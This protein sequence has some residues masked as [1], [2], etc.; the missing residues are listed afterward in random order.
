MGKKILA[1]DDDAHIRRI[2]QVSLERAGY[3]VATATNGVE[4]L[5]LLD[6]VE[7]DLVILDINMPY[8]DG[9]EVLKSMKDSPETASIP[10][11]MLTA[12]TADED[13]IKGWESGADSYLTKPF[14]EVELLQFVKRALG[15][16]ALAKDK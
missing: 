15:E 3:T 5:E 14:Y 1:V 9:H 12:N 6:T 8:M 2:V 4:A 11:I 10:V 16:P 13:V 7:P